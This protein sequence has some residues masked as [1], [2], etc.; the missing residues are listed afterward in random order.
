[1]G[2]LSLVLFFGVACLCLISRE[3]VL[4]L[5]IGLREA[6]RLKSLGN[7]GGRGFK[8]CY[9]FGHCQ[10][11]TAVELVGRGGGGDTHCDIS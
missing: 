10:V 6:L 11:L 7:S 9:Q 1:M 4:A 5:S 8:T 2:N 3:K